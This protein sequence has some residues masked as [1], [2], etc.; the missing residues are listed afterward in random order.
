MFDA[1]PMFL[2]PHKMPRV[3][4]QPFDV[5]LKP[6]GPNTLQ[7]HLN[8]RLADG[9][10]PHLI[11]NTQLLVLNVGMLGK[12]CKTI[13]QRIHCWYYLMNKSSP[14]KWLG[15]NKEDVGIVAKST[16]RNLTLYTEN[17]RLRGRHH[18]SLL[19][20]VVKAWQPCAFHT[21]FMETRSAR[22]L[23]ICMLRVFVQP[24]VRRSLQI[25]IKIVAKHKTTPY[26]KWSVVSNNCYQPNV[27]HA[28]AQ[29]MLIQNLQ[30][31][32]KHVRRQNNIS[33]LFRESCC[34]IMMV[35][36]ALHNLYAVN[37][38]WENPTAHK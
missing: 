19:V 34:H 6:K 14:S 21:L 8:L 7:F 37:C 10:H 13:T 9:C 12:C 30:L 17:A 11:W 38:V 25:S 2:V 32:V 29:C 35:G 23:C 24:R 18:I 4:T 5:P 1:N 26:I 15:S 27:V 33:D 20:R 36:F 3:A 31:V 16:C 22:I 28:L